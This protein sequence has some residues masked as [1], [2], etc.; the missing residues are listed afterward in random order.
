MNILIADDEPDIIE[1]VEFIVRGNFP[2]DIEIYFANNAVE[3]I[4]VLKRFNIELCI[5]DHNMPGGNGDLILKYIIDNKLNIF[6][7]L[8]STTTPE[9]M[10]ALYPRKFVAHNIV[11]PNIV[12]GVKALAEIIKNKAPQTNATVASSE[13][14][15]IPVSLNFLLKLGTT[16]S[17]IFIR[18]SDLKYLKC[19]HEGHNFTK[20]DRDKYVNK[21][22]D[23]SKLTKILTTSIGK[24]MEKK[25]MPLNEK[26]TAIHSQL[27]EAIAFTGMTEELA[28][29][30]KNHINQT[31]TTLMENKAVGN[32]WQDLS[33]LGLYPGELY[34]LHSMLA[35]TIIKK[36]AWNSE[37]TM[38]KLTMAAFLQDVTLTSTAVMKIYDHNHFLEIKDTL[39]SKESQSFFDH[40]LQSKDLLTFFKGIPPDID[41]IIFD[42]HEMPDG[43]GFPRKL[44]ASQLGPLSCLFIVSGILARYFLNNKA[45]F[46]LE[47][48]IEKFEPKGYSAGNFKESFNVIKN[49]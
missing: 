38:Y 18:M 34:T 2:I 19:F 15:Y 35:S 42:H 29:V 47:K 16:P 44:G 14:E 45:D 25:D 31:V 5:S 13:T 24:L 48:F 4:E 7:T 27:C 3:A 30:T 46:K 21:N 9:E 33:A 6:Y 17:D 12:E 40:P 39:T 23:Q 49:M 41:K 36:L 8:C 11:K 1:I 10:P 22:Y 43:S 32:L 20:E 37:A 26:M 28:D